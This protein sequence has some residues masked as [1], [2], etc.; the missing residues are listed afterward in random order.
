MTVN[1][2]KTT[3]KGAVCLLLAFVGACVQEGDQ[4]AQEVTQ[5]TPPNIVLILADD[6]GLGD[7]GC[8]NS[9]SKVPT[10]YLDGLAAQ[11]MRFSDAHSPSA[12]CTPTRYGLLTGRY[13]WRSELKSGV[14]GGE[15]PNLIKSG[16]LT[17]PAMLKKAG[18][19]TAGIGKWHLGL[20]VGKSTD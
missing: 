16:R 11:G 17:L 7:L 5:S 2:Q 6:L 9:A 13:C 4:L 12:V 14:L 1:I 10:P 8:Y 20:G 3:I 19:V 15:S 18:Y